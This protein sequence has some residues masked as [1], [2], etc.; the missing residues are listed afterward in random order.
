M[1]DGTK[2]C[3]TPRKK[4]KSKKKIPQPK[5]VNN[6]KDIRIFF[7]RTAPSPTNGSSNS[8]LIFNG[9]RTQAAQANF[10]SNAT[11]PSHSLI[12]AQLNTS[13]TKRGEKNSTVTGPY[14]AGG[15]RDT[16]LKGHLVTEHTG[17]IKLNNETLT[18]NQP[19]PGSPEKIVSNC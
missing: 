17:K 9:W 19:P 15:Y 1:I 7:E 16:E 11:T 10:S 12:R 5:G 18:T 2:A 13:L 14:T 6:L 4:V 8:K 3:R